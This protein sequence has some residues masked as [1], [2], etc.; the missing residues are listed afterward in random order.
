MGRM[1]DLAMSRDELD[2]LPLFGTPPYKLVR[3]QDPVT[4]HESAQKVDTTKMEGMVFNAI[5]T[6]GHDG[7]ISDEL[8]DRFFKGYSYSSVTARYKALEDKGLIEVIG[9]RKGNSGRNQR[10]MRVKI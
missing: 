2:S 1:K 9:K 10:I 4:S 3:R 6:F 7:V 5:K 8:R